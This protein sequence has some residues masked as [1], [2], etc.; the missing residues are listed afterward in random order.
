MIFGVLVAYEAKTDKTWCLKWP[1]LYPFTNL[2]AWYH[3]VRGNS[4]VYL[5]SRQ[6]MPCETTICTQVQPGH[7]YKHNRI[8]FGG[9]SVNRTYKE[10]GLQILAL[11]SWMLTNSPRQTPVF[12][13][14]NSRLLDTLTI[15]LSHHL[16]DHWSEII[17][18]CLGCS[19]DCLV[20]SAPILV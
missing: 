1:I 9:L 12:Y 8:F 11:K 7:T 4:H 3:F 14:T 6:H 17:K 10:R 5:L 19:P 13:S 15:T 2:W 16:W 18:T 20:M